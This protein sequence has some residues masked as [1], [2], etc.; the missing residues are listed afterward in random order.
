MTKQN[1]GLITQWPTQGEDNKQQQRQQQQQQ[2]QQKQKQQKQQKQPPQQQQQPP[3]RQQQEQQN[4]K[5]RVRGTRT[6]LPSGL[7]AQYPA[8][9]E[10]REQRTIQGQRPKHNRGQSKEIQRHSYS[11]S[12]EL[13]GREKPRCKMQRLKP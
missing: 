11:N 6:M 8:L 10:K 7:F 12:R 3:P 9:G 4:N 13:R 5:T 2:K 1:A